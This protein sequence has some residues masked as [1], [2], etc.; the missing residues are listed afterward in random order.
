MKYVYADYN[1][2][3]EEMSSLPNN[4]SRPKETFHRRDAEVAERLIYR[5]L[6]RGA[7]IYKLQSKYSLLVRERPI[8]IIQD[9]VIIC[10]PASQRETNTY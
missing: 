7:E 6:P 5:F 10:F 2:L 1:R 8:V 9:R 3:P 4:R